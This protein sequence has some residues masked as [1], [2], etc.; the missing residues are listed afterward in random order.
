MLPRRSHNVT[1]TMLTG[2]FIFE[3]FGSH[4]PRHLFPIRC[5]LLFRRVLGV[6]AQSQQILL[7]DAAFRIPMLCQV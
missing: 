5:L 2:R 1:Y 3:E 7:S 6:C 4:R